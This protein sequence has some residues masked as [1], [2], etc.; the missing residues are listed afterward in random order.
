LV[1]LQALGITHV[2]NVASFV[3]NHFP[4]V[5]DCAC[6]CACACA[7]VLVPVCLCGCACVAVPVP[8]PICMHQAPG[9]LRGSAPA[10]M[11]LCLHLCCFGCRELRG[12]CVYVCMCVCVCLCVFGPCSGLHTARSSCWTWRMRPCLPFCRWPSP[13]F[14]THSQTAAP[15]SCIGPCQPLREYVCLLTRRVRAC[16]VCVCVCRVR[17]CACC[18]PCLCG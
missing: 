8:V 7:C 18:R 2:L 4:E 9:H 10:P 13:F 17:V 16:C 1:S 6:A 3:P 5:C 11:P 15:F 12:W 14:A